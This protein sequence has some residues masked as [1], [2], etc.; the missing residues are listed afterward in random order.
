M[1][2]VIRLFT[3]HIDGFAALQFWTISNRFAT[4]FDKIITFEFCRPACVRQLPQDARKKLRIF[5]FV[6][7]RSPFSIAYDFHIRQSYWFVSVQSASSRLPLPPP[8]PSML[9]SQMGKYIFFFSVRSTPFS[10]VY[11]FICVVV[12]ALSSL[13]GCFDFEYIEFAL[14]QSRACSVCLSFVDSQIDA[15]CHY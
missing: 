4:I 12:V 1:T 2:V 6:M 14:T 5:I 8:S 10:F 13:F 7:R 15:I 11:I 3:F 9:Y